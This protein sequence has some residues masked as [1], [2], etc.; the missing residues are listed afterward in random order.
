MSKFNHHTPLYERLFAN[1]ERVGDCIV[2]KGDAH[3]NGYGYIN[4]RGRRFTTHRVSW[5]LH[6]GP[7]PAGLFVCHTCDNPPC[8][9]PDHLWLGTTSENTA[10]MVAK[11]RSNPWPGLDAA[12]AAHAAKRARLVVECKHG[13]R[14]TPENTYVSPEGKRSCRDCWRENSRRWKAK[15]RALGEAS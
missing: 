7:I 9:N 1:T 10:D 13:H 2:W 4:S 3:R 5:A 6:F 11:G 12:A 14:R 8:I 15:K